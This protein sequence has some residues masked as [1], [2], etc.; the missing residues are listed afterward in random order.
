M[1]DLKLELQRPDVTMKELYYDFAN[2]WGNFN[3]SIVPQSAKLLDMDY[4]SW[5]EHTYK[6]ENKDT[7]PSHL[8]PAYTYF[9]VLGNNRIIGAINIRQCLNDYLFN[10]GGHI[11]YGIRPTERKK[12]YAELML[13]MAL[14][15]C[16][17]MD[18]Q[19]V[20]VTCDRDNI[21]SAKTIL[22]NGGILENEIVKENGN[23]TQ[24]YWIT[25]VD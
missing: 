25:V 17:E 11:G 13:K 15:K 4:K 10:F 6:V 24:R 14:E 5:L 8:V 7:C 16:R 9:L 1:I 23:I 20:L 2:E 22:A 3:E 18:I 12:G 19:K 21:A